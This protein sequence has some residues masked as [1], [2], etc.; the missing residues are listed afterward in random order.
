M[1]ELASFPE[2]SRQRAL[3]RFRL[4]RA[5]LED[6]RSVAV[7][8]REATI[9]YRTPAVLAGAA[10]ELPGWPRSRVSHGSIAVIDASFRLYC[11][12]QVTCICWLSFAVTRLHPLHLDESETH[13]RCFRVNE[14]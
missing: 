14:G 6:G 10:I 7:I 12:R 13:S 11:K 1:P 2:S 5:H 9:S 8:A 3:Q 4:L